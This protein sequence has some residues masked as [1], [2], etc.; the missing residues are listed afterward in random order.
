MIEGKRYIAFTQPYFFPYIG[1]W[2][3]IHAAD[4]FLVA[5]NVHYL[6]QHPHGQLLMQ[7]QGDAAAGSQH[8]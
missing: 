6:K 2:Q 7:R 5:D 3:L 8:L 4:I 1:Y